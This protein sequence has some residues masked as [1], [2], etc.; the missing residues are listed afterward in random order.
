MSFK[1]IA[2]RNGAAI[3]L[4]IDQNIVITNDQ[5]DFLVIRQRY[6]LRNTGL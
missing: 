6:P 1:N 4:I 2:F 5:R 3:A